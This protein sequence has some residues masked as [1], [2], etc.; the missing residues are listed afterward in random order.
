MGL[1]PL[2]LEPPFKIEY[3]LHRTRH[4]VCDVAN[5]LAVVDKFT[6][7]AL[8]SAGVLSGDDYRIVSEVV[9]RLGEFVDRSE[10]AFCLVTIGRSL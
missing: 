3:E 4:P 9:Y 6:C 2:E 8:V 10:D 1:P 7:D 5:V